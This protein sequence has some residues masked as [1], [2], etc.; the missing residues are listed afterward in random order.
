MEVNENFSSSKVDDDVKFVWCC[1]KPLK[2]RDHFLVNSHSTERESHQQAASD[3]P[4]VLE[5][6]QDVDCERLQRIDPMW[7]DLMS[8]GT[9]KAAK[10]TAKAKQRPNPRQGQGQEQKQKQ[11]QRNA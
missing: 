11:R 3:H 1:V 5:R 2:F 7:V 6:E 4:S 8:K 10:V 9:A